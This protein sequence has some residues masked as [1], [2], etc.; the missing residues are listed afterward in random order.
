MRKTVMLYAWCITLRVLA[1]T[2]LCLTIAIVNLIN[3]FWSSTDLYVLEEFDPGGL[4]SVYDFID[5]FLGH[6]NLSYTTFLLQVT[7]VNRK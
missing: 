7:P 5:V 3:L 6:V 1:K 4:G 2:N